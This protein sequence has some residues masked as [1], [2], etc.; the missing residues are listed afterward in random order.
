MQGLKGLE[1]VAVGS[2]GNPAWVAWSCLRREA[3]LKGLLVGGSEGAVEREK[4]EAGK[5]AMVMRGRVVEGV[6]ETLAAVIRALKR[7]GLQGEAAQVS[8]AQP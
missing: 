8:P 1:A 7:E 3:L 4:E 2:G 6:V 5:V